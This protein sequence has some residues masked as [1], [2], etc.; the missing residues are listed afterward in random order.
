LIELISYKDRDG[1]LYNHDDILYRFVAKSYQIHFEQLMTSGLYEN[2]V[3]QNLIIPFQQNTENHLKREQW[4]ATLQPQKVAIVSY[5]FEWSFLQL[6]AAALC[7]LKVFKLAIS[8][9]MTLKDGTPYNILFDSKNPLFIDHLSFKVTDFSTPWAGYKQF[10]QMFI[11]PLMLE[12]YGILPAAKA[13]TIFANGVDYGTMQKLVPTEKKF[14]GF[15]YLNIH[16]AAKLEKSTSKQK[17]HTA[18]NKEKL[19]NL[20]DLLQLKIEQLQPSK[21]VTLWGNYYTETIMQGSYFQAKRDLVETYLKKTPSTILLDLG[22]NDGT[23]SKLANKYAQQ[24]IAAD[25]DITAVN[26]MFAS[27]KNERIHP[28]LIDIKEPNLP[29]GFF[30][31][32]RTNFFERNKNIDTILCLALLHHLVIGY[33]LNFYLIA[34]LLSEN[35]KHLII[36]FIPKEDEKVNIL[37]ANREDVFI[38]Y[39]Q[40]EFEIAFGSYFNILEKQVIAGS[41]RVLYLMYKWEESKPA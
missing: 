29:T 8:Y 20:L 37:L 11:F 21:K 28:I 3:Q 2:L 25:F 16:L 39:T 24:V 33:N 17:K 30:Y 18:F 12:S 13:L 14:S 6:Q 1:H 10:C 23:F 15:Y 4:F 40:K 41:S 5:P 36:E 9:G 32:E 19:S 35:C 26:Y 31:R 38:D 22:C 34:K 27:I 7:T